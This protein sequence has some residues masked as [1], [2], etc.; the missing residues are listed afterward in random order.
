[1][2]HLE[3]ISPVD[4]RYRSKCEDL[5][6]YFSESGLIR[7]RLKIEIEYLIKISQHLGFNHLIDEIK[8]RDI[9][10]NYKFNI[11]EAK[12]IKEIEKVTNHDVKAIEYYLRKRHEIPKEICKWVHYGL[13][14]QDINTS[15]NMLQIKEAWVMVQ[16]TEL[17]NLQN[18][19]TELQTSFKNIPMLSRTHGQ[20]ASPTTLGKELAVFIERI[21]YAISMEQQTPWSSKFGG[22]VG[23]FNSLVLAHPELNWNLIADDLMTDLGLTRSTFTTQIDHYDHLAAHFDNYKRINT[24]LIDLCRDIWTY[25]SMDYFKLAVIKDEVGSSAMPHKVNPIDFENAEG[26]LGIANSLFEFFSRK[27]PISRL[28]RDLTDSTVLRNVGVAFSHTLI[29]I[30]S[31]M[32]GLSKLEVNKEKIARDLRENWVVVVEGVQILLKR[33]GIDDAY[34]K[35]KELTRGEVNVE[36]LFKWIE[37]LE[38]SDSVKTQI[39]TLNPESYIGNV[40]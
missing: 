38:V 8:L 15:A 7:Y 6:S 1:M 25:I 39:K 29:A 34:E 35:V 11:T 14:S 3:S 31:I 9:C 2:D 21:S 30:K 22:A 12:K 4:G 23:N 28:Q 24:I 27:L 26:N 13:T 10:S 5:S 40:W 19:L 37:E 16:W 36:A 17:Q 33:E 18:Q 32:K 20:P